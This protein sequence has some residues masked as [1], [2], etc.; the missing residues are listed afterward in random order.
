[1]AVWNAKP[2]G[3]SLIELM[4]T[5]A[6]LAILATIAVPLAQVAV[7]RSKEQDL[8]S[9]LRQIRE[10]LDAYK[11]AADEGLIFR[12]ADE[13]GYPKSLTVLVDGVENIKDPRHRKIYFMRQLPR[14]PL[15][16]DSTAA[17][18]TTWG[19][20]SY[21]SSRD[22]PREGDDIFD[23]YSQAQGSGLNGIPYRE[24]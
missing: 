17:P 20:R 10:A 1:M 15:Y 4:V 24:W 12:S 21:A 11:Q 13:S 19:K 7:Q 9:G 8:R 18:E 2:T 16:P 6:I 3:F 23:V 5:L 22:D 14:D